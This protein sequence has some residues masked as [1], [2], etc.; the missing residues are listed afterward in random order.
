MHRLSD[1]HEGTLDGRLA[2][3]PPTPSTTVAV[4]IEP[5]TA[6]TPAAQHAAWM[7][8]NLLAR[9]EGLVERVALI[10]NDQIPMPTRVIPLAPRD[11]DLREALLHG[12]GKVGAVRVEAAATAPAGALRL[13]VG[14]GP[15]APDTVLV[16]GERAWGGISRSSIASADPGSPLPLGPYVA[17]SLASAY[18]F[19]TIRDAGVAAWADSAFHSVWSYSASAMPPVGAADTG[20]HSIAAALDAILAGCGAVGST[21][22]HAIWATPGLT[23]RVSVADADTDGVDLSNLNR[24]PI[25]G[26]DSL[27]RGK[28]SEA[29]RICGDA[30]VDIDAHDGPV[31]DVADSGRLLVS[32]VDSNTSREAVQ[33]TYPAQIL[34]ASTEGMRAELLRCDP[35]SGAPCLRCFNSPEAPVADAELRRRFLAAPLDQQRELAEASGQTLEEATRWAIEGTCG[36]ESDRLMERMRTDDQGTRAFAVGFVSVMAGT[37][38]AAQTLKESLAVGPLREHVSRAVMQFFDPLAATNRPQAYLRDE[39]CPMC[40]TTAIGRPTWIKRHESYLRARD[41]RLSSSAA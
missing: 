28:A 34:S 10:C 30:D 15:A 36:Y 9:Q 2:P 38:L 11:L 16:W 13:V 37:M 17:A 8:V 19:M 27:G 22:L 7:L 14:T 29:K 26:R 35:I 4:E 18:V 12:A 33:G 20:P 40:G 25:Y 31:G 23:G 41:A 21:W 24:C 6:E 39:S 5:T 32:A 1:R 3:I